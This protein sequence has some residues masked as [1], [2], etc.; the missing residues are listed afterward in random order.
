MAILEDELRFADRLDSG[1]RR[2]RGAPGAAISGGSEND[3][4][5]S[6]A[7]LILRFT[8]DRHVGE[9]L[10]SRVVFFFRAR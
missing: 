3:A 4:L 1:R 10:D 6:D 7:R 8:R 9:R 5:R 2:P